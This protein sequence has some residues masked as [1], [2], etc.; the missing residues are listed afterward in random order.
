M[1]DFLARPR[2]PFGM[3]RI[4]GERAHVPFAS[5]NSPFSKQT[6]EFCEDRN[7]RIIV[8]TSLWETLEV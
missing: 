3:T 2:S 6:A 1:T 5:L 4:K 8:L 7:L